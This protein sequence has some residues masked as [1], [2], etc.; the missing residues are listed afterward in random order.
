M[1]ED[2]GGGDLADVEAAVPRLGGLDG[3]APVRAVREVTGLVPQVGGV[4]VAA[5]RQQ[6]EA[7][8][9]Q[10][11]DGPVAQ[12]VH[13]AVQAGLQPGQG[14]HVGAVVGVNVGLGEGGQGVPHHQAQPALLLPWRSWNI[15]NYTT[16]LTE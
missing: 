1:T 12:P 2:G 9:L 13:P 14:R 11:G 10:P 16:G 7:V 4:G 8:L 15:R 5:H 3:E 6:V